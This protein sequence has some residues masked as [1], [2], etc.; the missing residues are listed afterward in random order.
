MAMQDVYQQPTIAKLA[1]L[2][3]AG[4]GEPAPRRGARR[5]AARAGDAAAHTWCAGCCS[6]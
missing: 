4:A 5:R 6:C 1:A 3:G 2:A